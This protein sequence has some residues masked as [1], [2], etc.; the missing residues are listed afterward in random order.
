MTSSECCAVF[1]DKPLQRQRT[2]AA[3]LFNEIIRPSEDPVLMIDGDFTQMLDD[4]G[5]SRRLRCRFECAIKCAGVM[6]GRVV[7]DRPMPSI[8]ASCQCSP[9][10]SGSLSLRRG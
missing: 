5:V 6:S 9:A 10:C 7:F 3:N 1:P 4:K 2:A 8:A